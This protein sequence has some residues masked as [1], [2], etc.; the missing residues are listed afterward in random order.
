MPS[1]T[2]TWTSCVGVNL[3]MQAGLWHNER[4]E[5]KAKLERKFMENMAQLR[6]QQYLAAYGLGAR[7]LDLTVSSATVAEA[8]QA[9]N[10]TPGQ[11]AKTLSLLVAGKPILLVTAGDTKLD[12]HKYKQY[13]HCKAQ[14]CP[15]ENLTQWVGFSAGGVCPFALQSGVTVYIDKSLTRFDLIYPAGGTAHSAV[16]LTLAELMMLTQVKE[17]IDVCKLA[18]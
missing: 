14:M 13:F 7:Y 16:R 5:G 17:L 15:R 1:C 8:A 10:C 18:A 11:I 9:L 12:N 3:R 2:R 4:A 6:V